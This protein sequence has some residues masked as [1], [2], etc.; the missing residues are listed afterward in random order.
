MSPEEGTAQDALLCGRSYW[1]QGILCHRVGS[2]GTSLLFLGD[3]LGGDCGQRILT[4]FLEELRQKQSQDGML[5]R[6]SARA[7]FQARSIFILPCPNPDA[8]RVKSGGVGED[9]PFFQGVQAM[10]ARYPRTLWSANGRG[11][12]PSRN[13]NYRFAEY[14]SVCPARVSAFGYCGAY[15]ESEPESAA[16]AR[17]ARALR[18]R[19]LV[20]LTEGR[21]SLCYPSDLPALHALC[22]RYAPYDYQ[23]ENLDATLEGWA[24]QELGTPFLRISASKREGEAL[25][26]LLRP[27]FF[28]LCGY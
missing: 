1:G 10:L 21:N 7:L 19:L 26:S 2:G 3:L 8:L 22:T 15:P 27:L 6:L 9:S 14:K 20:H 4:L 12:D 13:F 23:R 28:A 25:Y 18:P 16:L 5:F 11:V 17:L 24:K